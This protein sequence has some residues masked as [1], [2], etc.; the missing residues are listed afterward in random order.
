MKTL[1]LLLGSCFLAQAQAPTFK[2]G[3]VQLSSL[4]SQGI[5]TIN[6]DNNRNE[7]I[8]AISSFSSIYNLT[9]CYWVSPQGPQINFTCTQNV[10]SVGYLF[11]Q[12]TPLIYSSTFT[13]YFF[14]ANQNTSAIWKPPINLTL[15]SKPTVAAML[16][17]FMISDV[18]YAS[19]YLQ[20]INNASAINISRTL[21]VRSVNFS[22]IL[23]Q[24]YGPYNLIFS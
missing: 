16:S 3:I 15:I 13:Y 19:I 21:N 4:Q 7:I 9:S 17:G 18:S 24:N 11:Y 10:Q 12:K 20:A 5:Y 23:I 22:F 6:Q 8:L 14:E 2:T 1:L